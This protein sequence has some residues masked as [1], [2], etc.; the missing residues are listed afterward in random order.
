M[1]IKVRGNAAP[2]AVGVALFDPAA[3]PEGDDGRVVEVLQVYGDSLCDAA[4]VPAP[5]AGFLEGCVEPTEEVDGANGDGRA[6]NAGDT[7]AEE[8]VAALEVEDAGQGEVEGAGGASMD[9]LLTDCLLQAI[10]TQ[11]HP[12]SP[13]GPIREGLT[14]VPPLPP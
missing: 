5:N 14:R 6:A 3:P 2:L 9:D 1:A 8:G 11:A 4:A 7:G 10:K 13:R 12:C